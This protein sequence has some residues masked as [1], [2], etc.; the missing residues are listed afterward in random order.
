VI[1]APT[2]DYRGVSCLRCRRP[3]PVSARVANFQD[4]IENGRTDIP[5]TFIARCKLCGHEA[6]YLITAVEKFD[7]EPRTRIR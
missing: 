4:Q 2:K 3:V 7:G 5:H 1:A 6:L